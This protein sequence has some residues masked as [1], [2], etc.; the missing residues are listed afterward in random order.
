MAGDTN[1]ISDVFVRDRVAGTTERVSVSSAGRQGND[2][3][4]YPRIGADGRLV[5]F[6]SSASNLVADDRNAVADVF[7]H[8]RATGTTER[9]SVTGAGAEANGAISEGEL[10]EGSE[11][12]AM[13]SDGRVVGF[14]SSSSNLVAGD[15]NRSD[16]V[17]ARDLAAHTTE[18]VSG[19]RR[20]TP[21]AGRLALKPWPARAGRTLTAAVVVRAGGG[22]VPDAR[23]ACVA[24]AGG[25]RLAASVHRF[26]GST[27]RCAWRIPATARG[28]R[29]TGSIDA[30]TPGG[31]ASRRFA[32]RVSR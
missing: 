8:D 1:G 28:K 12:P 14:V 26:V 18:L 3:S 17:F 27:A 19:G 13:S 31:T 4:W 23:V 6:E 15:T 22:P 2:E 30:H 29:V 9:L 5:A 32:G 21:R 11:F 20:W 24:S 10:K 16:D 25:R 7:V